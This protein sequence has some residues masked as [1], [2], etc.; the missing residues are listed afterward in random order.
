MGTV[1]RKVRRKLKIWLAVLVFALLFGIWVLW[2]NTALQLTE[3]DVHSAF[4]PDGFEGYRIAHVSDLHNTEI[5]E[6]NQTLLAMLEQAEPDIIALTGDMVDSVNTDLTVVLRFA[7]AAMKIAPCYFVTGNHER[8][9]AFAEMEQALIERGV[10]VMRD[11]AIRLER[12]GDAISLIGVDDPQF[13]QLTAEKLDGL[14]TDGY[15][16]VLS[17]RPEKFDLY[18]ACRVDLVLS[19]HAHGGQVRLPWIGGLYAPHQGILPAYDGDLYIDGRTNMVVSRGI[20]N[21]SFPLRFNN[22]PEVVCITLHQIKEV[23]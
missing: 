18:V 4:L 19:G 11:T 9:I 21:S 23:G 1:D 7:E 10:T 13:S 17:H 12:N 8:H 5:G 6:D 14:C 22:R 16:V 15:T 20:G 2:G 3:I